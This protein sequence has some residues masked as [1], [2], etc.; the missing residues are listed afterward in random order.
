MILILHTGADSVQIELRRGPT[1]SH[2]YSGDIHHR[3][4]AAFRSLL[5]M[6]VLGHTPD[7]LVILMQV[8]IWETLI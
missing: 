2:S 5:E 1:V 4:A 6:Q 7:L 8:K 3:A